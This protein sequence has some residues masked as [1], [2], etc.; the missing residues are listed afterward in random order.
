MNLKLKTGVM[1]LTRAGF[2]SLFLFSGLL[3]LMAFPASAQKILQTYDKPLPEM[4][5]IGQMTFE[6]A[7]TLQQDTP[8]SDE[9]LAYAVR[10]PKGWS[11]QGGGAT[12]MFGLSNRVLTELA[13]YNSPPRGEIPQSF[14]RLQALTL[15]YQTTASQWFTLWAQERGLTLE[16]LKNHPDGRV[17]ALYITLEGDTTYAVRMLAQVNGKNMIVAEYFIPVDVWDDEKAMQASVIHSFRLKSM[18]NVTIED[19]KSHEFL[20][21]AAFSYPS[22]WRLQVSPVRTA[23]QM[24]ARAISN[25]SSRTLNGQIDVS[26]VS[27]NIVESLENEI[28]RYKSDLETTGLVI[29]DKI[30]KK[31][32]YKLDP[33]MKFALVEVYKADDSTRRLVGY[34]LWLAVMSSGDYYYFITMLTPS[35]DDDYSI[36]ARNSEIYK[37]V[38]ESVKPSL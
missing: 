15:D 16:G 23:D 6:Q 27:A 17:E 13:R 37:L 20:D 2:R 29:G 14:F 9:A 32:G 18:Q 24:S 33:A 10:I 25:S 1:Q 30:E 35:R 22:S 4:A 11:A 34:E 19:M 28:Q 36:W 31:T 21:V 5:L 3:T 7:T 38:L 8:Y 12:D 26:L